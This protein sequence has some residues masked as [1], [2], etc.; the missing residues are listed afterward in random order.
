MGL[1]CIQFG[2]R[3]PIQRRARFVAQV[4][5]LAAQGF[6]SKKAQRAQ[7]A[8]AFQLPRTP[9][10]NEQ[11][12]YFF[13][14]RIHARYAHTRASER[15]SEK[16]RNCQ[17]CLFAHLSYRLLQCNQR[18]SLDFGTGNP[19]PPSAHLPSSNRKPN[20]FNYLTLPASNLLT[21]MGNLVILG[22]HSHEGA[23][24]DVPV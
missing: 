17:S 23:Y 13:L 9:P 3:C 10:H 15:A 4:E 14:L 20:E 19:C 8:T 22:I 5:S 11:I 16:T 2:C 21:M 6:R 7:K 24:D 18:L 12:I 1:I